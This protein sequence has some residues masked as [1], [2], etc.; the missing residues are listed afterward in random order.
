MEMAG[1][2][3]EWLGRQ[4]S[5]PRNLR[6][7]KPLRRLIIPDH[8]ICNYDSVLRQFVT[9]VRYYFCAGNIVAKIGE[10]NQ[11]DKF[12]FMRSVLAI[13]SDLP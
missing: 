9:T 7:C 5:Q 13:C 2:G 6:L 10:G 8:L 4:D 11:Q 12:L 1:N 3:W